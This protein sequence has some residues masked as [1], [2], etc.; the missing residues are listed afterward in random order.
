MFPSLTFSLAAHNALNYNL[1]QAGF[2]K[3]NWPHAV[4]QKKAEIN[5]IPENH[6]LKTWYDVRK[7]ENASL[8]L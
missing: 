4:T 3:R 2:S 6:C 1:T 7:T 8:I 5:M